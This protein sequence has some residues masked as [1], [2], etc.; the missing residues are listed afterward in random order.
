MANAILSRSPRCRDTRCPAN[1][2]RGRRLYVRAAD[3][4]GYVPAGWVCRA[5]HAISVDLPENVRYRPQS[6]EKPAE[7]VD[8][9]LGRLFKNSELFFWGA[10]NKSQ[11][12][13]YKALATQYDLDFRSGT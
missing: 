5:G 8:E 7:G 10:F 1:N 11:P 2:R 12:Q 3:N 6:H 13:V 9:L 4:A